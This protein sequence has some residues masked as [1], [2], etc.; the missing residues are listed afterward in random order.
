MDLD[1]NIRGG[2]WTQRKDKMH[3]LAFWLPTFVSKGKGPVFLNIKFYLTGGSPDS[4]VDLSVPY[5]PH[6]LQIQCDQIG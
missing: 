1:T 6:V 4:S 3:V 2:G 5:I